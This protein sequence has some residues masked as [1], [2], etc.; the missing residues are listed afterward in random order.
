M[1]SANNLIQ[2]VN[3]KNPNQVQP[4]PTVKPK[5]TDRDAK[6][7]NALFSEMQ[8]AFPAWRNAFPDQDAIDQAKKTWAKALIEN[9][10]TNP[11]QVAMG[12]RKARKSSSPYFPS[13]GQFIEWC[14]PSFEDFGLPDEREAFEEACKNSHSITRAQWSHPVVY[15]AGRETGFFS[16]KSRT[17]AQTYPSFKVRYKRLCERVLK[18][19]DFT[20]QLPEFLPPP[21]RGE[22]AKP[23]TIKKH[24]SELKQ[25]MG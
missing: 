16:L 14:N 12:V 7:I 25:L 1:Q 4:E 18:G 21:P 20:G 15:L 8:G 13:V 24:L 23:A 9:G 5:I 6:V 11:Q 2:S 17:E 3:L 19:E 22:P 10:V